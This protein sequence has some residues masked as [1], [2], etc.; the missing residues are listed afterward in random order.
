MVP[1]SRLIR[2]T[3]PSSSRILI[4]G[5]FDM[6]EAAFRHL[7]RAGW[8]LLV[9]AIVTNACAQITK[10][11]TPA[12]TFT[13][14]PTESA[15]ASPSENQPD[16]VIRQAMK[17]LSRSLGVDTSAIALVSLERENFPDAALGCAQ[18]GEMA[19][20]VVTPGYKII[21]DADD[22]QYELHANLNGTMIRCVPMS[23]PV[24]HIPDF[25][26]D[27]PEASQPT[28]T[29]NLTPDAKVDKTEVETVAAALRR[30][31]Y[32]GLK[33]AM[34]SEFWLG[35][36]ASE[37]SAVTRDEAI[38]K[39]ENLY[40]GPGLVRVYPE[41]SVQK[42]L[43]DW[44]SAAPYS[45]LIYST[46]WGEGQKDDAILL[47][48]EQADTLHWAGLFYIFDG[49]KNTAYGDRAAQLPPSPTQNLKVITDAIEGKAYDT[50]KSLVTASVLLGF[51]NSE[52]SHLS[53]DAFVEALRDYLELG[54]VKVRFDVDVTRLL[55][56]WSPEPPCNE[57]LY[58]T[59]WGEDQT[60]DGIL[61]LRVESGALRWSGLLYIYSHLKETAYAEPP[62]E[63][64][65]AT[66]LE[67]MV[68]I[69]AGPFIMGS[70]ASEI[71]SIQAACGAADS[72]CNVG[73]FEDEAPQRQ[74]TLSAYYIDK[75][76][77]TVAQFKAFVAATG[78]ET[79]SV[80][81][82]DAI[83]YTWRAFDTPERQD[84]P[85]RWMSWHDANAYCQWAD[86]RLPTEAEWEKAARGSEGLIY[87]W[88]NTWDDA[89]VP[90]GDTAPVT[91][92][93]NG[94]SPY[95]VLG[96]AGGVWEWVN[97]WYDA[98]YYQHAPTVDPP[99]PGQARDKVLRGGAFGNANWKH[100]T[101]HRH[102][103]GAEGYAHDHSFRCA[104]SE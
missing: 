5:G 12:P 67:G 88:G 85:V 65:Q 89:R 46:G 11:P 4:I 60:D 82:G 68:F 26:T 45:R 99:G 95:G 13:L 1:T 39:L 76:E 97:D 64:E 59:G 6:T 79:T 43:P 54:Q 27:E 10:E 22:A 18:P 3:R 23:T 35:F 17:A 14:P 16:E 19:A 25:T 96:M 69:P 75:T 101:A 83:Q 48:E 74:V 47:F 73:Q 24:V 100:R 8:L 41:T 37:A 62:S 80:A 58:S 78:Y 77:V 87:P 42:L 72:G 44:S 102:F 92:F 91:A 21:L 2:E 94:A 29:P 61:C 53:P 103:G 7:Q 66:E 33:M 15:A 34:S 36:F 38:E 28:P 93:S 51:H 86:K 32:D 57:L 84:H 98:F 81:K 70:N 49:L 20:A 31:D 50:L 56:E 90:H 55:P 9:L 71:G 40:L 30:K 63:E 52:P 104:K